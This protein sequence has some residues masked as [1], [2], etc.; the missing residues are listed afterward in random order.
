[1]TYLT[2]WCAAIDTKQL[3]CI[4]HSMEFPHSPA[5]SG[6]TSCCLWV[7]WWTEET[8]KN[9]LWPLHSGPDRLKNRFLIEKYYCKLDFERWIRKR[10]LLCCKYSVG[11]W[12]HF[13]PN[14]WPYGINLLTNPTTLRPPRPRVKAG[15]AHANFK[16]MWLNETDLL[17]IIDISHDFFWFIYCWFTPV[18]LL[19]RLVLL[20]CFTVD[21]DAARSAFLEPDM[22]PAPRRFCLWM[23][24]VLTGHQVP[25]FCAL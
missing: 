22:F 13:F 3:G 16:F 24:F 4:L 11:I 7:L 14:T 2:K 6:P 21:A 8:S 5:V 18:S 12:D 10:K 25:N 17:M 15:L 19:R 20:L 1:M 23:R 9:N